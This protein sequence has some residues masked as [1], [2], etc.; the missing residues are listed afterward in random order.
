MKRL[1]TL[2]VVGVFH[3]SGAAAQIDGNT[4]HRWCTGPNLACTAFVQGFI[5]GNAQADYYSARRYSVVCIPA[6]TT[7]EQ[8][9]DVVRHYLANH[10]QD[11]DLSAGLLLLRAFNSAWPMREVT[12]RI[13][14][15]ERLRQN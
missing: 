15:D 4:L 3:A 11:H 5:E 8:S 13:G 1:L 12:C 10:P 14:F 2:V 6:G 7:L 9:V